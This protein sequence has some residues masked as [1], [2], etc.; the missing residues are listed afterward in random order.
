MRYL[1]KVEKSNLI[2]FIKPTILRETSD[3]TQVTTDKYTAYNNLYSDDNEKPSIDILI[4][5]VNYGEFDAIKR[6]IINFYNMV[7]IKYD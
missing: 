3:Y 4:D 5:K 7:G 1:D 6:D 2:L